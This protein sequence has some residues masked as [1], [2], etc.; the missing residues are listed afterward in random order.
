[1]RMIVIFLGLLAATKVGVKE[2]LYRSAADDV[3][4]AAYRVRAVDA[5][6]KTDTSRKI[7]LN[8]KTWADQAN[9]VLIMGNAQVPV[10]LWQTEHEAWAKRFRN[11]YLSLVLEKHAGGVRCDFDIVNGIAT[12]RAL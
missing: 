9:S 8:D 3:I 11:P 7:G 6:T 5:C 10:Y 12:A 1:M 4:V 2:W